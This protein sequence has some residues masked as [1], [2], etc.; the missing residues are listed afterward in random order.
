MFVKILY[1]PDHIF[2]YFS[3]QKKTLE[4]NAR[5]PL[6]KK[7]KEQ[8]NE[9]SEGETIKDIANMLYETAMLRSGFILP[10]TLSFADRIERMMRLSMDIPLDEP[11]S[12]YHL[13]KEVLKKN[14]GCRCC[15]S[16]VKSP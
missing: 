6:V 13:L 7:L 3:S 9:D 1:K 15:F 2:R 8:Y 4:L 12:Y 16:T 14:I 10:D 11:V 5:H